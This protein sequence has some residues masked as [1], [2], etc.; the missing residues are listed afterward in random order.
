MMGFTCRTTPGGWETA[1]TAAI[2]SIHIFNRRDTMSNASVPLARPL[3]GNGAEKLLSHPPSSLWFTEGHKR[4]SVFHI[5][6]DPWKPYFPLLLQ[7][8]KGAWEPRPSPTLKAQDSLGWGRIPCSDLPNP[9]G[10]RAALSK[11]AKNKPWTGRPLSEGRVFLKGTGFCE[12]PEFGSA[13]SS[14]ILT[15]EKWCPGWGQGE[16]IHEASRPLKSHASV[17]G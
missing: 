7:G 11:V 2:I 12:M 8:Y 9:W 1:T 6:W 14:Y 10:K 17:F 3:L 5:I 16:G 15:I 4:L 13:V